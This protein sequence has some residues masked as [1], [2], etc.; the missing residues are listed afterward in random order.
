MARIDPDR[1]IGTVLRGI[2]SGDRLVP[3]TMSE[4]EHDALAALDRLASRITRLEE[5][6][7]EAVP[8]INGAIHSDQPWRVETAEG[9]MARLHA[10]LAAGVGDTENGKR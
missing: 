1:D 4:D 8:Y 2:G 9:V 5:A 3:G 10:A 7:Q 6:L